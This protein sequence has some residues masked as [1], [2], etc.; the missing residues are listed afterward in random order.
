MSDNEGLQERLAYKSVLDR[1]S[2]ILTDAEVNQPSSHLLAFSDRKKGLWEDDSGAMLMVDGVAS[3][4]MVA[5]RQGRHRVTLSEM[6]YTEEEGGPFSTDVRV[7]TVTRRPFPPFSPRICESRVVTVGAVGVVP[8]MVYSAESDTNEGTSQEILNFF[9]AHDASGFSNQQI[10][11]ISELLDDITTYRPVMTEQGPA[12]YSSFDNVTGGQKGKVLEGLKKEG[13]L[14]EDFIESTLQM[15]DGQVQ[16]LTR[17][18]IE[19]GLH[20]ILDALVT[21][22]K[23][24]PM[25][26][27]VDWDNVRVS[28]DGYGKFPQ[29]D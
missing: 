26:P 7:L 18:D 29:I 4:S 3:M 15:L 12:Y 20:I 28:R 8:A 14:H 11:T 10:E 23:S 24:H 22:D 19:P 5:M 1:C 2:E 25:L 16:K 9:Y 6:S 21:R 13:F 27:N 17:Y